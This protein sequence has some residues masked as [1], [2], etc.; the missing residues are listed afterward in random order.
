MRLGGFVLRSGRFVPR[1]PGLIVLIIGAVLLTML[2]VRGLNIGPLQTDVIIIRAWF[3]EVGAEG[4]SARYFGVNQRHVLVGPLYS[5][6][7]LLFG[8]N[9]LPYNIIFQGSRILEGV[10]MGGVVYGITRRR[11]LAVCAGLALALTVIRV[12]ELY[13]G[14]NWF[15][16]P[17]LALLLASSYAYVRGLTSRRQPSPPNHIAL[18]PNPSPAG[19]GCRE[20]EWRRTAWFVA[21]NLLYIVSILIYESGIPWFLVNLYLGWLLRA[22]QPQRTRL[23]RTVRDMLP[24]IVCAGVL[25]FAVLFIYIPWQGLAPDNSAASPLRVFRQIGTILTFPRLYMDTFRLT[26][27]D[28][29]LGLIVVFA[30]VA[31]VV[32]LGAI[33][34]SPPKSS[35]PQTERATGVSQGEA[36]LAPTSKQQALRRSP[37]EAEAWDFLALFA[38]AIL[39]VV[40][41]TLVGTSNQIGEEY[42]DR[43]TFGRAAGIALFW[44]TLIFWLCELLRTRWKTVMAVGIAAAVLIGPGF[45]WLWIYQDYAH[46]A[47]AEIDRIAAAI[48]EVRR[49]VYSP[50]HFVIL[51]D[52][53]WIVTRLNDASDVV[54]HEAQQKVWDAD[55]DA[56]IDV[57][58]TGAY[59]ENYT[60]IPGTCQTVNSQASAGMCLNMDQ[61]HS[62]RWAFGGTH[63]NANVVIVRYDARAGKMTILPALELKDLEQAG[64]NITTAGPTTLRT[65][66]E[67]LA[68]PLAQKP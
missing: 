29:Y 65:N 59:K 1:S 33:R 4:F 36:C 27:G 37:T 54:V 21:A 28:G 24:S 42:L 66:T 57:L 13:Q 6:A 45:A 64:Y 40:A 26:V 50:V 41:A 44:V 5:F 43:I 16:E 8:E 19:E 49:V 62:S 25:T 31:M 63:P 60:N 22:D 17:T 48:L 15:I 47:R 11:A 53:D 12:R 58:K 56:S 55:G 10:F 2:V 7:Y 30:V 39:M 38:L 46:A 35:A 52:P 67:R 34:T 68:V 23:W 20:G 61:I 9:D 3:K 14:I 51:T 32:G 18:T